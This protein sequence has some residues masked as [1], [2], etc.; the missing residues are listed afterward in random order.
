MTMTSRERIEAA[1]R[2]R[3]PDRT[4]LFEY[5]LQ[6]P[7]ADIV[8]GRPY[9]ADPVG[10]PLLIK[11]REWE[12]AI[13][14]CATDIVELAVRLG[15]D[16]LYVIPNPPSSGETGGNLPHFEEFADDPVT[17]LERRNDTEAAKA[18]S[19]PDETLLI[20]EYIRNEMLKHEVDLPILAPAY[21]HGV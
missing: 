18:P 3:E 12:F 2:R 11:E 15:H 21:V 1:L 6:S 8:L 5:V 9:A 13:R 10:G 4:P 14:Q 20:Y 17:A 16:M 7:I 19:P